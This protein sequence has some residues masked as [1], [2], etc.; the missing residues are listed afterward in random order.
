M[1]RLITAKSYFVPQCHIA[2]ASLTKGPCALNAAT[3]RDSLKPVK[4]RE[5]NKHQTTLTIMPAKIAPETLALIKGWPLFYRIDLIRRNR[6]RW[7]FFQSM[8]DADVMA[9]LHKHDL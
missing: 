3:F 8:T 4:C 1:T 5:F 7:P 6:D 2:S 9:W